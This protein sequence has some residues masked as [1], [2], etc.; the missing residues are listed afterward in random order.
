MRVRARL[1]PPRRD[2]PGALGQRHRQLRR[3]AG[4]RRPAAVPRRPARRPGEH[5]RRR[6]LRD[7]A[8]GDRYLILDCGPLGDG[9]HGHYDALSV[10][11]W[12]GD[13]AL[14]MDPG[15]FTY[16]EGEP[17]LRHW[18]R[19]TAAHNTVCVDG[20]DQTP[21][22]RGRSSLPSAEARLLGERAPT[23]L[24]AE[25]RSP[26]YEA[27]HR[28]RVIFV[29]GRYWVIED[30]L[31]GERPHRY[32][33]RWHLAPGPRP[34]CGPDGVTSP[35]VA[36]T[37]LG[38]RSIALEDGW[39]S[40]RYGIREPGAGASAPWR[41][42]S[43]RA[44]ITLLAPARARRPGPDPERRRRHAC[45]VGDERIVLASD[46]A[47]A[48]SRRAAPQRAAAAADDGRGALAAPAR[49]RAGRALRADVREVP[50]RRQPARR[51]PLRG[52]RRHAPRAPRARSARRRRRPCPRPRSAP[53][54]SRSRTTASCPRCRRW[55][56]AR[57][58]SRTCS[59]RRSRRGSSPT[60][61]SSRPRPRASTS[62]GRVLAYAKVQR[63]DGERRG[64]RGAG[65]PGRRARAAR[66]R[67]RRAT[68]SCSRRSKAAGSTTCDG[69][70]ER[71]LHALG[72]ALAP[73]A[74]AGA[75]TSRRLR[76]ARPATGSRRPPR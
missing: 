19:G 18:F 9:G 30:V 47:R 58:C 72:R 6:R 76:A 11:A 40:P 52:R 12:A 44:F 61:P 54:C 65:R 69:R 24:V 53:C 37:I 42:A 22:A 32:D 14:V 67:A 13:H 5:V 71:A 66:A 64:P 73:P 25:V 34:A 56:P 59:A 36:I 43:T 16:A 49:R 29:D 63:D 41:P 55:R 31:T 46:R 3:A 10:E 51:L 62:D 23:D 39:I 45:Y 20:A 60:P 2:D 4:P 50:R 70:L 1:P 27:I 48:R 38:A 21:Y 33:L 17:N 35:T 15:R 28:R 7:P 8:P 57:R 75:S 74:L 26:V 68:C